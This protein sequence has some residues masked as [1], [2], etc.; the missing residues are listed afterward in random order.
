MNVVAFVPSEGTFLVNLGFW[1][2]EDFY[3]VWTHWHELPE[4][5]KPQ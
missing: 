3:D 4:H 5:P 2:A 1:A